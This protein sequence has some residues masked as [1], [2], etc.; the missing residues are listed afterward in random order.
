MLLRHGKTSVEDLTSVLWA[1]PASI[2]R[3]LARLELRGKVHCTHGGAM[4]TT[5]S[6]Y[7]PFRF[8]ASFHVREDHFDAEMKRIVGAAAALVKEHETVDLFTG[9]TTTLLAKQLQHWHHIHV[10]PKESPVSQP[11]SSPK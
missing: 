6:I 7:E 3:D 2:R 11:V 4:L 10:I 1:F 8:G 5:G 9:T